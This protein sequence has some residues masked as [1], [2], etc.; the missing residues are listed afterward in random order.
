MQ[1]IA[2]LWNQHSLSWLTYQRHQSD[3]MM[4][5]KKNEVNKIKIKEQASLWDHGWHLFFWSGHYLRISKHV[6]GCKI[7]M[8]V[9]SSQNICMSVSLGA[10]FSL[11]KSYLPCTI[12]AIHYNKFKFTPLWK[13]KHLRKLL[14]GTAA[15]TFS[16]DFQTAWHGGDARGGKI[17]RRSYM[18]WP[19]ARWTVHTRVK[20]YVFTMMHYSRT[21]LTSKAP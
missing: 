18:P 4:R 13:V 21:L 16:L 14:L 12:W 8:K 7:E 5:G 6:K 3:N 11:F 20:I 10:P 15:L 17:F 2:I 19:A 1:L 9:L